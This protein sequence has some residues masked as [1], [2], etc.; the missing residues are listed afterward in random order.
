MRQSKRFVSRSRRR[1]FSPLMLVGV[2]VSVVVGL[3]GA[4]VFILPH[5]G[6]HAAAVNMDCTRTNMGQDKYHRSNQAYHHRYHHSYQ[7][8]R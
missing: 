1:R 2:V 6:T 3:I 8:Q 7:H 5:I 4:V